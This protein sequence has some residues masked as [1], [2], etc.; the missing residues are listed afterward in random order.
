MGAGTSGL[1]DLLAAILVGTTQQICT[2]VDEVARGDAPAKLNER[3]VTG[4]LA[5]CR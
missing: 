5:G 2:R 1:D 3:R 4:R